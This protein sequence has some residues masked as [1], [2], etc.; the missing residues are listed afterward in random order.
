MYFDND[1]EEDLLSKL[2]KSGKS[3]LGIK[4]HYHDVF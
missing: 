2:L 1:D 4:K 3:D